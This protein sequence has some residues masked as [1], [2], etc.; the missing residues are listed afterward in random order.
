[1]NS[2][3]PTLTFQSMT[4]DVVQRAGQVWL[5]AAEIAEA[6]GY[7]R[8]DKV[9]QIYER[10]QDEFS[11]CMTQTLKLRVS[12]LQREIRLFSL[13]GAHLIAM[14]A[15]TAV[16]KAFRRWVLDILDHEVGGM[17]V[18]SQPSPLRDGLWYVKVV[19]G[20]ITFQLGAAGCYLIRAEELP[21]LVREPA[22]IPIDLLPKIIA[23]ASERLAPWVENHVRRVRA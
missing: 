7:S 21:K 1:M 15:R 10:N 13:R 2:I 18:E 3:T 6:L 19:G 8:A 17:Q 20:Q 23:A 9:T 14:F 22:Q 12:G 4:F 11:P 5:R 16:A